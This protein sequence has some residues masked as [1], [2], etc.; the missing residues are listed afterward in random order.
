MY[1]IAGKR[2]EEYHF[3][4]ET[5]ARGQKLEITMGRDYLTREARNAGLILSQY[6]IREILSSLETLGYVKISRGR[7]GTRI[8]R[9]GL[10]LLESG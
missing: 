4:L 8:T 9:K 1:Q 5:L 6:E 2:L 3:L 10:L 7:G